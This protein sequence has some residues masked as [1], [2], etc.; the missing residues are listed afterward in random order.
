MTRAAIEKGRKL[1]SDPNAI[2]YS[3]MKDLKT[4]LQA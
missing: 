3:S 2:R 1:I 4:A